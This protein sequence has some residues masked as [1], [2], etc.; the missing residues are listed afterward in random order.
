[1]ETLKA[2]SLFLL[3][4]FSFY[5]KVDVDYKNLFHVLYQIYVIIEIG[6]AHLVDAFTNRFYKEF[7][8]ERA[9]RSI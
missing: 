5:K 9:E 2:E 7:K 3:F 8:I 1:M 4:L 6:A